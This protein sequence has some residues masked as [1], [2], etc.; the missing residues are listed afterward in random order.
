MYSGIPLICDFRPGLTYKRQFCQRAA[1]PVEPAIS[2]PTGLKRV[3]SVTEVLLV[4]FKE[5]TREMPPRRCTSSR[6][7]DAAKF[8]LF[9]VHG[10]WAIL[11]LVVFVTCGT[12]HE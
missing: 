10:S 5:A 12:L 7:V 8:I 1:L 6:D 9:F 3:L 11:G 4:V 2:A